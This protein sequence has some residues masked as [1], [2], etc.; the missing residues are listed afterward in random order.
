MKKVCI[1]LLVLLVLG[2]ACYGAVS[3]DIYVR[4][5]VF[6]AN[7]QGINTK[8]DILLEQMKVQ[9]EE[10]NAQMKEL[11]EE[12]KELR[13]EMK[14]QREEHNSQIE[15]LRHDIA[16]LTRVV[17]VLST[18]VDAIDKRMDGMEARIG[19]LKNDFDGRIGELRNGIYLWLVIFG[20][21]LGMPAVQKMFQSI[22]E[23]KP[24]LT[25]E[26]VKRLIDEAMSNHA[27]S[28]SGN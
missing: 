22:T 27:A 7:M 13:T 8:L 15:A 2:S 12:M 1:S 11:R 3:E 23:R 25:V 4:K 5:D 20:I 26:D 21:V 16:E 6:E 18:R 19:N 14:T 9:R 28:S 24:S 10:H 17:S